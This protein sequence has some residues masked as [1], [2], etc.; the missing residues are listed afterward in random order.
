MT[1]SID[2]DGA[3]PDVHHLHE[4]WIRTGE[5][6]DHHPEGSSET[7]V[8]E[9]KTSMDRV[10]RLSRALTGETQVP[11]PSVSNMS[12]SLGESGGPLTETKGS[13]H[14]KIGATSTHRNSDR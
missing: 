3:P 11:S 12:K 7:G 5:P 14:C 8:A 13:S 2:R 4:P 10:P 1:N 9:A 6:Q